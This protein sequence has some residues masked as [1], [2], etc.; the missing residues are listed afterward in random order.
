MFGQALLSLHR[1][2]V[3]VQY[4][5]ETNQLGSDFA[6]DMAQ[7]NAEVDGFFSAH[8]YCLQLSNEQI[9]QE[10]GEEAAATVQ[11]YGG[12][13]CTLAVAMANAVKHADPYQQAKTPTIGAMDA[14]QAR[15]DQTY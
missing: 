1:T 8:P 14:V 15:I 6:Y 10:Y 2:T 3:R 13:V 4:L 7:I 9:A 5:R 11:Y 12:M